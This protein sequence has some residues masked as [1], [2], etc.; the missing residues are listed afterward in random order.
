M[1]VLLV[2]SLLPVMAVRAQVNNPRFKH[3]GIADGLSQSSVYCMY[4]DKK[5]FVWIGTTYGLSRYDGYEFKHFKYQKENPHSISSNEL[6][7]L[8][9]DDAG[10]LLVGTAAGLDIFDRKKERFDKILLSGQQSAVGFVRTIYKDSREYIWAG[11]EKGLLQYDPSARSLKPVALNTLAGVHVASAISEDAEHVLWIGYGNTIVRYDP[12]TQKLLPLPRSLQ[13]NPYFTRSA[14]YIIKHD[15]AQNVWIGTERD[16]LIVLYDKGQRCV[17]YRADTRPV[18]LNNDM[19]RAIG[20]EKENTWIGTRNGLYIINEKGEITRHLQVDKYDP[21]SLSGN[22][23]MCFMNDNA[24]STWVGTFAGGISIN[25]PGNDNFSYIRERLD[26]K[27]GLNNK[28]VSRIVEDKQQNLL[29]ATEGGGLNFFDRKKNDYHYI[30]VSP[31]SDHLINQEIVKTIQLDE[32]DNAWIGTLEG[33]FYYDRSSGITRRY[34]LSTSAQTILEE[35][36]YAL[37]KD[38]DGLWIGS[39]GG[40]LYLRKDGL[41]SRYKHDPREPLSLVSNSINA[42]LKDAYGGVWVGTENGLSY[43][44]KGA[45]RF[46]NYLAED[47][48]SLNGNSIL[49]IFEDVNGVIW[50]GTRGAGIKL[51]NRQENRF[52]TIDAG[53]GLPDNIVHGIVQDRQGSLWISFNQSI[54]KIVLKKKIPPFDPGDVQVTNY[55]VNNGLGSNEFLTATCNTTA[56][57]I[58]FGGVN[59]IVSFQPEKMVLNKIKPPVVLT[60]LLIKNTPAVIDGDH[61]PLTESVTYAKEITLTH[62]QA[63][64]TLRFAA[65]NYINS[66]T[67]QYAYMLEGL[68]GE[69]DW[70]YVGN[71]QSATYT[72]LDAGTYTFKV[73]AA[74][75]DGLW[76][77]AYTTLRIRVLPPIWKTWYA[78]LLYTAIIG[79]LLYLFYAY[80]IKTDR[81]KNDL[82]MQQLNREKDQEL[83]QRKLS[84]FTNISHEIKTPLTLIL[85][86]MEKLVTLVQ[87]NTKALSQL[88]MMQRNGERLLR[89]TNQL[90]DFRKLESGDMQLQVQEND[91]VYF[92]KEIVSSFEVYAQ[93]RD[94]QLSCET[95]GEKIMAWFDEDKLEK[96][97]FNLLSNALKFTPPGGK[98]TLSLEKTNDEVVLSVKD[99]GNGISADHLE[100]IFQPFY[101]YNDTGARID[102]TGIGLAFTKALAELHHGTIMVDSTTA[103]AS[104]TGGSTCFTVTFPSERAR[105][106]DA[107]IHEMNAKAERLSYQP[108]IPLRLTGDEQG[109]QEPVA[110]EMEDKPVMLIVEDNPEVLS[111]MTTHFGTTYLVHVAANGKEGWEAAVKLIPDIII[112][113]VMMPEMNGTELC[114]E[115][116]TDP[117]TSHIPVIL[118]T[119]RTPLAYRVEGFETGADDYITKPFSLALLQVRVNNLLTSRKLLRER[120]RKDITLQPTNIA[121]TPADELFLGKV[122]QFIDDNIMEPSLNVEELGREV[123]MS[124]VTLYR[125]IKALTS[126]STIEF[127]RSVRLKKAAQF[128]KTKEYTVNEVA[129]MV[130]FSDV[131]YFRKWFKQEFGRTPKEFASDQKNQG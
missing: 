112:S 5:G 98:V 76:N 11:T 90:L 44:K 3:L 38:E 121:I 1:I 48:G 130:G 62:E 40:L 30:H 45:D 10:N 95:A 59:G 12:A 91:I 20:F 56:G 111:F 29:I 61:S 92:V 102:G 19:V 118:L 25:Q 107:E 15:A 28:V 46:V 109:E 101:H 115:L 37:A 31:N 72:N 27:L 104:G 82:Q 117:R 57:E 14:V 78:Y 13:Q 127:I 123:S 71:Q 64:F 79:A 106:A 103:S 122:M 105:Y 53:N 94:V 32:K 65:L 85:A 99:N 83:I 22:S 75:N 33:L 131:D 110:G 66:R 120:Y 42:I 63:Y 7:A 74:N 9:E 47:P 4:Q 84:F 125:K 116:K 70:N 54:A 35:Q 67:N 97:L 68:S 108:V 36:V 16:G 128:L 8:A 60:D 50:A 52:Y 58:M 73:K 100:K 96:I 6:I 80:S 87:G 77:N 18:P 17:N 2:W 93:H 89:L 88:T 55:S 21:A 129:Y 23:I 86:P 113:D 119:A 26:Q 81:L 43:L 34:P 51:F 49:C 41:I 39:K 24:G 124:R 114:R 69:K 126:Q